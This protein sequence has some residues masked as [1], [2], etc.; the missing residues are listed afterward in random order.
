MIVL[1]RI[2]RTEP[3]T[4]NGYLRVFRSNFVDMEAQTSH[5]AGLVEFVAKLGASRVAD[6]EGLYPSHPMAQNGN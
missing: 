3:F 5:E 1:R 4:E 2:P 6:Q